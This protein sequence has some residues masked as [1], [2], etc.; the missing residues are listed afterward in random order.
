M[1]NL[2]KRIFK[3][4]LC[5]AVAVPAFV[6]CID[7][8]AIWDK[9][10]DLEFRLDSLESNLNNQVAALNALMTDGSTIKTCVKNNDGSYSI[11][12][13]NGTKF[14]AMP[15]GTAFSS[16]VSCVEVDG[17]NYWATYDA[18]GNLVPLADASGNPIPVQSDIHVKIEDGVYYLVVDGKEYATGVE[19]EEQVQVFS[20]VTPLTDESGQVY[21]V[22]FTFGEGWEMTVTVDGYQGVLFKLSTVNT[23]VLTEYFIDFGESQTFLMDTKGIVDYVMQIPDG[24]RVKENLDK[25]TGDMYVTIT[26]PA[27]EIVEMGAG[28][29]TGDLKVVSVVEGGKAAITKL[30]LS[31]EPFKTYNVTK[32]IAEITPY[33]GVQKFIYGISPLTEYNKERILESV[34]KH[35]YEF[36]SLPDGCVETTDP[37]NLPHT[38]IYPELNEEQTYMF[39]V[40]PVLYREG[41]EDVAGFYINEDRFFEYNLTPMSA[42]IE[43]QGTSLLNAQ[44]KVKVTGATQMYAGV[45]GAGDQAL[46]EILAGVNN[47]VYDLVTDPEIFLYAGEASRFPH[48]EFETYL[49]PATAYIAWVLPVEEGKTT[50]TV[51][52]I[53]YT[54]FKTKEVKAGGSIEVSVSEATA[55]KSSLS[56]TVSAKDAAMIYYAYLDNTTGGR[57]AGDG[58]ENA[59]KFNLITESANFKEVR[60]N[61]V[62]AAI[63]DLMPETTMWLY[64]VAVGHD[65]LYGKV[66]CVSATTKPVSFNNYVVEVSPV[67]VLAEEAT[68][69]IT[70]TGGEVVDYLYWVGRVA[71]PFWVETCTGDL[72]VAQKFMA[73]NPEYDVVA[74]VMRANGAVASDGTLKLTGLTLAKEHV[75]VVLAKD[76]NGD[77]SHAASCTFETLS[78]NYGS[79]YQPEG[80]DKWNETKA[81]IEENIEWRK[82]LFRDKPSDS[83]GYA[84]Y[85]FNIKIPHDLTAYIS[86]SYPDKFD[87]ENADLAETILAFENYCSEARDRP[88]NGAPLTEEQEEALRY[89]VENGNEYTMINSYNVFESYAHGDPQAGRFTYFS[90]A[91]HNEATCPTWENGV[92]TNYVEKQNAMS[93]KVDI[94]YLTEWVRESCNYIYNG[95]PNHKYSR[96]LTDKAKINQLAQT[97][98]EINTPYFKDKSPYIFVNDGSAVQVTNAYAA[99]T[100]STTGEV[101]D[102]VFVI[103]KDSTNSYYDPMIIEVP[104]YYKK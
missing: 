30:T 71:D 16:I 31:T 46:E 10:E 3:S 78:L 75:F 36:V 49:D 1:N 67:E 84:F 25:L 92:C 74:K 14:T 81:W 17:K 32:M 98:L 68:V 41:A 52:D 55:T 66:S 58:I 26:A 60:G 72:T 8:D 90:A 22:K 93:R 23:S 11:E 69:K 77:Y 13:S 34:C 73:S 83:Y 87:P 102:K 97:W 86:T 103:L 18:D 7:S 79:N 43:V 82:D 9:L 88:L 15:K 40:V 59:S 76:K 85:S 6:S 12:L 57:Y 94:E 21:A 38:E 51:S 96:V 64:A 91:G 54:E 33:K 104:N 100:D 70:V 53:V 28:V 29:A 44:L 2:V 24:W 37:I 19:A 42:S 61:S 5:V 80:S 62:E 39:W 47:G 63:E 65:G 95:D 45:Y 4:L 48:P 89:T 20:S 99:G 56:Q 101:L 27:K 50:F 35:V